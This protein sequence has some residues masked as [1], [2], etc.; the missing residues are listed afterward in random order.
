M[1]ICTYIYIHICINVYIYICTYTYIYVHI[2]IY[3][4]VYIYPYIY[5]YMYIG[6]PINSTDVNT[7]TVTI[8]KKMKMSNLQ[9]LKYTSSSS[10]TIAPPQ[11]PS[12]ST[13]EHSSNKS[14]AKGSPLPPTHESSTK[15]VKKIYKDGDII[16]LQG[17]VLTLRIS[18]SDILYPYTGYIGVAVSVNNNINDKLPKSGDNGENK[19]N[20]LKEYIGDVYGKLLV[21]VESEGCLN[22]YS[23][24]VNNDTDS[25]NGNKNSE[26]I[27]MSIASAAIVIRVQETPKK[28]V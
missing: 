16:T 3:I 23:Y 19:E 21:S 12:S 26:N 22:T 18:Y 15:S 6:N 17:S 5:I 4:Y 1:Y 9:T 10:S 7:A 11:E 28:Y 25:K 2:Y 13:K 8:G 24:N 27:Q 20:N 14:S